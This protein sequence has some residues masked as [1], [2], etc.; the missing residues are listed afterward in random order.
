MPLTLDLDHPPARPASPRPPG[1]TQHLDCRP[2]HGPLTRGLGVGLT[3]PLGRATCCSSAMRKC[4]GRNDL[5]PVS[6]QPALDQAR[7]E[8]EPLKLQP[9]T[10]T[11]LAWSLW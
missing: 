8:D 5:V 9:R 3:A 10:R 1:S 2:P 11:T 6:C 4:V 7:P